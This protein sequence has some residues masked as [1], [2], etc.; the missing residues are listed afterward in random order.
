MKFIVPLVCTLFLFGCNDT[1]NTEKAST[2]QNNNVTAEDVNL[3]SVHEPEVVVPQTAEII[4]TP[5]NAAIT[6]TKPNP[7]T[8]VKAEAKKPSIP[9]TV[10]E[11]IPKAE[12]DG[13]AL[14]G[15][16]CASCHG[17]KADKPALGKSQVIAGWT[18]SQIEEALN[19]YQSGSYGK[20]M[21]AVMQGQAKSLN[22]EEIRSLAKYIS[23]L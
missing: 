11:M 13:S 22:S 1:A 18:A 4:T 12:A 9:K 2:V 17:A 8:E 20:E 19:G 14:F 6:E 21:K 7:V 15:K 16:K 3:T 23:A 10:K 5:S